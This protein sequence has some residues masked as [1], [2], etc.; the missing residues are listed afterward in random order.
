[1]RT[2]IIITSLLAA[3]V[4]AAPAALPIDPSS[5]ISSDIE[6]RQ[7][8]ASF[9]YHFLPLNPLLTLPPKQTRTIRVLLAEDTSDTAVQAEV[10]ANGKPVAISGTFR[11][12]DNVKANRAGVVS[13]SGRC[14]LFKDK[15]GK[16]LVAQIRS[17]G[18][19]VVF[20]SV[21]LGGG[22]IVCQ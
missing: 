2:S 22:V 4:T 10:P 11:L 8:R 17:G 14:K 13:G 6:T 3:I 20:G 18:D 15:A 19:D 7:V 12:G 9:P 1:M 5:F 16:Q 21:E